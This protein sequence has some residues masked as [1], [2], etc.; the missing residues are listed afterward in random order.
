MKCAENKVSKSI[1]SRLKQLNHM[2]H[3]RSQLEAAKQACLA[4]L[5]ERC[6]TQDEQATV[7]RYLAK[8][9]RDQGH[10]AMIKH[11]IAE[12]LNHAK[13]GSF[14]ESMLWLFQAEESY[15]HNDN[16]IEQLTKRLSIMV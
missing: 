12:G 6:L 7:Y 9:S 2:R 5:K 1:Q 15:K 11:Y 8:I 3:D 13:E 10:E 4:L 14:V 16:I